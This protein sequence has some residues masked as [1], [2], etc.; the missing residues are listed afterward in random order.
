MIGI[1]Q[2][3]GEIAPCASASIHEQWLAL[4]G[5]AI[6]VSN[7][8]LERQL[9]RRICRPGHAVRLRNGMSVRRISAEESQFRLCLLLG[10]HEVG[11]LSLAKTK[12]SAADEKLEADSRIS[13]LNVGDESTL[14]DP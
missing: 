4:V 12:S 10:G 14:G 13:D 3:F 8:C 9:R 5:L 1:F 7:G 11:S 6:V 2:E